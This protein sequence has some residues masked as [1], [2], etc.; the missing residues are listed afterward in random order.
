MSANL[1]LKVTELG[2]YLRWLMRAPAT[3]RAGQIALIPKGYRDLC[4][5]PLGKMGS[6]VTGRTTK[7]LQN[8]AAI[9]CDDGND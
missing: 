5:S 7:L 8:E 1:R 4:P 3:N 6:A 2:Y 9:S